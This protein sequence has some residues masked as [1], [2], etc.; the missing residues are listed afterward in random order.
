LKLRTLPKDYPQLKFDFDRTTWEVSANIKFAT[1]RFF[2]ISFS[3]S[4][5]RA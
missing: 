1:V 3:V 5:S 4:L 2:C